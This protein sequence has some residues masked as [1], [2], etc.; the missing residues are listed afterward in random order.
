M[1]ADE[2]IFWIEMLIDAGIIKKELLN[3]LIHEGTELLKIMARSR[4]TAKGNP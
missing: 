3:D 4:K 1:N 2:S